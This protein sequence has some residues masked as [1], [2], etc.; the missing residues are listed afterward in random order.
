[1]PSRNLIAGGQLD[2]LTSSLLKAHKLSNS[3]PPFSVPFAA[4]PL[5]EVDPTQPS[6]SHHHPI[7][8]SISSRK[9]VMDW[10]ETH[11]LGITPLLSQWAQQV[12]SHNLLV[13][14]SPHVDNGLSHAHP[15][16]TLTIQR[17]FLQSVAPRLPTNFTL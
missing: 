5:S 9:P 2:H 1:V 6:P 17:M 13:G 15:V 14:L 7:S 8:T 4:Y 11:G 3:Y 10:R 16:C 12:V